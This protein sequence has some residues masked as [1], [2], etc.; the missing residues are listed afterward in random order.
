MTLIGS[1]KLSRSRDSRSE[2]HMI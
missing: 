1:I 2:H